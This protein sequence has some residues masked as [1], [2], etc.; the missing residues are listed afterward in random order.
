MNPAVREAAWGLVRRAETAGIRGRLA[1]PAQMASLVRDTG[2]ILPDWYVELLTTIPLCD[3]EIGWPAFAPRPGDEGILW[4]YLSNPETLRAEMLECYPGM[5][6]V[7]RGYVNL[8]SDTEGSGDPY[9]FPTDRGDDPPVFRFGQEAGKD[10]D[11]LIARGW[12]RVSAH[13]SDLFRSAPVMVWNEE[14]ASWKG[15]YGRLGQ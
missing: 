10:P 7:K 15:I 13:L 2:D 11:I 8:A 9:F 3:L 1:D 6:L 12:T 14:T 5:A 4:M